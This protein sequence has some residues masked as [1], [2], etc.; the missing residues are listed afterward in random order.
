MT[1]IKAIYAT[2]ITFDFFET[3]QVRQLFVYFDGMTVQ[4]EEEF[5]NKCSKAGIT[6]YKCFTVGMNAKKRAIIETGG[7]LDNDVARPYKYSP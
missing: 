3:T 1:E 5:M 6:V 4:D 7:Y 2:D